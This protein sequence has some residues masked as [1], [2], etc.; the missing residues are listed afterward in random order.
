MESSSPTPSDDSPLT[1][2]DE[3][4]GSPSSSTSSPLATSGISDSEPA[5][6]KLRMP[7]FTPRV[8]RTWPAADEIALLETFA[9]YQAMHGRRPWPRDLAPLLR[10]R[11][12]SE[13]RRMP[14]QITRRL[15]ILRGRYERAVSDLSLGHMPGTDVDLRIYNLSKLIWEG[16]PPRGLNRARVADAREDPRDFSE[17]AALYPCLA[18]EVERIDAQSSAAGSLKRAFERISDKRAE[19]LEAKVKRLQMAEAMSRAELDCLRT[20]VACTIVEWNM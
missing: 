13:H 14:E 11:I 5:V 16:A 10:R 15:D 17:L 8:R 3:S 12:Q 7:H 19:L 20:K 2:T 1:F 9:E 6:A 18:R 4:P